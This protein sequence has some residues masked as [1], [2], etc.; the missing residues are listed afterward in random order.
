MTPADIISKD[1]HTPDTVLIASGHVNYA[2]LSQG[3]W[4]QVLLLIPAVF[5]LGTYT[6]YN[7]AACQCELPEEGGEGVKGHL[8]LQRAEQATQMSR[9][10]EQ[11]QRLE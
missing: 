10:E 5:P 6:Q 7:L 2:T 3:R 1:S 9:R 4:D 8:P 11:F